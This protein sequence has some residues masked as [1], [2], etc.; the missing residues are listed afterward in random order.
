[1]VVSH[2]IE[3][4]RHALEQW[5]TDCAMED[6]VGLCPELTWNQVFLAVDYLSRTG[7]VRVTL[8]KNRTYRVQ[9]V[10]VET[11]GSS[12]AS[13]AQEIRAGEVTRGISRP[14]DQSGLAERKR[15]SLG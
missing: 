3:Q 11:S 2:I 8:D 12:Y 6:V 1:M 4:V 13:I 7:Q 5:G 10:R 14:A 9:A 15:M